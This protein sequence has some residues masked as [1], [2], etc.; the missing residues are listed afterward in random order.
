MIRSLTFVTGALLLSACDLYQQND[1]ISQ[2][3]Q[4]SYIVGPKGF[5]VPSGCRSASG[6]TYS[7]SPS[8]CTRDFVVAQQTANPQSLTNP[9]APGDPLAGPVGNAASVYLGGDT[10]AVSGN[11]PPRS[12]GTLTTVQQPTTE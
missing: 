1:V 10:G 7:S 5:I 8:G 3:R 4:P 2:A 12:Q 6:S 11:A 9:T